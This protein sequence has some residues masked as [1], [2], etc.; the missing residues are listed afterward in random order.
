MRVHDCPQVP[1]GCDKVRVS[2][3]GLTRVVGVHDC[4]PFDFCA[5]RSGDHARQFLGD[6]RG[7]LVVDDYSG[8]KTLFTQGITEVGCWAHA[9]RLFFELHQANASTQA[10]QALR[11]IAELYR[12]EADAGGLGPPQRQAHRHQ[13]ARP[14]MAAFQ[15]WIAGVRPR[16]ANGSGLAKALDYTVRRWPALVRYLDDGR[17]PIDNNAIERAI[18]PIALGRKN[19]LFAGS[20]SAGERAAAIMSLIATAKQNGHDPYA[21]LKDV[22]TRLPTHP[23]RRIE[24]LLPHRW[25]PAT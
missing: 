21:Y 24:E 17:L 23:D 13:H 2:T 6:Y 10:E 9:R 8:Y 14:I 12:I 25:K 4:A 5:S 7:A 1:T 15:E 16:V 11:F 18:R 22:I 19:W 3:I 20:R